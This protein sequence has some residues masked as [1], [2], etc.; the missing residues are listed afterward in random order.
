MR[1]L[2]VHLPS[3]HG[4]HR[5]VGWGIGW[6]LLLLLMLLLLLLLLLLPPL[7]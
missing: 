4:T 3:L 7:H 2:L 6:R 1:L 5:S